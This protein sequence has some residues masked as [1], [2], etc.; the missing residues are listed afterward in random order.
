MSA[1]RPEPLDRTLSRLVVQSLIKLGM[2]T[3]DVLHGELQHVNLPW[4]YPPLQSDATIFEVPLQSYLETGR[5]VNVTALLT[6]WQDAL[7]LLR[8]SP[9]KVLTMDGYRLASTVLP[10]ARK[11]ER[12]LYFSIPEGWPGSVSDRAAITLTLECAAL[13]SVNAKIAEFVSDDDNFYVT[14]PDGNQIGIRDGL[15]IVA[16][17]IWDVP[18]D[19]LVQEMLKAPRGDVWEGCD[20]NIISKVRSIAWEHQS[21]IK[22]FEA[23]DWCLQTLRIIDGSRALL[24]AVRRIKVTAYQM[25]RRIDVLSECSS[26][27]ARRGITDRQ[28]IMMLYDLLVPEV[29]NVSQFASKIYTGFREP[30]AVLTQTKLTKIEETLRDMLEHEQKLYAMTKAEKP[31]A[32]G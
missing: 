8:N 21:R 3:D 13:A 4:Q 30:S 14:L 17:E 24:E 29:L 2:G 9:N 18:V 23:V 1:M 10:H 19:G 20:W 5:W 26:I 31:L 11:L 15:P 6:F 27:M 22:D 12:N 7:M 32:K 28:R 16:S 25:Q